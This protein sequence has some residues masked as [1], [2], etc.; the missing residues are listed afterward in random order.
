VQ[1]KFWLALVHAVQAT[2]AMPKFFLSA[3]L[4]IVV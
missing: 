4:K 3:A 2:E 1:E